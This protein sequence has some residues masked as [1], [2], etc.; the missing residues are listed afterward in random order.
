[1]PPWH[2][3]PPRQAGAAA[4]LGAAMTGRG[5]AAGLARAGNGCCADTAEQST[6]EAIIAVRIPG[7]AIGINV[8]R[9]A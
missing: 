3:A 1:M 5:A 4:G 8:H 6:R 2:A 9:L 7:N